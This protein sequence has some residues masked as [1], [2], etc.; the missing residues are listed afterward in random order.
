MGVC[1][2]LVAAAWAVVPQ[3]ANVPAADPS[4]RATAPSSLPREADRFGARPVLTAAQW[5]KLDQSVDRALA[6]LAHSQERDGSFR[7]HES[8]QPAVT[9]LCAMAF[10][11][12]GHVPDEGEYRETL[13]RAVDYVLGSQTADGTIMRNIDG[14]GSQFEANYNH[15]IAGLMLGEVYGMTSSPRQE[16]IRS[17]IEQ[18]LTLSRKEQLRPKRF[19]EDRG[20]W[21]Y[22]RQFGVTDADLSVTAWELM[23]LRSARNAEFDVPEAWIA[24]A[25]EYVRRTFDR[26]ERGFRYGLRGEDGYCSRG[27]V[28]AG[29]VA[30]ALGGEHES[31]MAQLAGKWILHHGFDRYNSSQHPEDR[32]HY[33]AFYCSQ[34]MFQ[35]GGSYWFDFFPKLL[36]TLVANQNRDGSWA[37]EANGNDSKYGNLYTTALAVLALSPPYQILPI[38]QR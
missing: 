7:T 28:G 24:E 5:D 4:T 29:V 1:L 9:S 35:L 13:G 25:M 11:A 17:A 19:P 33:S 20:G 21:R 14:R 6:F 27:M 26:R 34:A 10:L 31:E 32:Y 8:G 30:L 18:A 16:R 3:Q 12:R 22:M 2:L 37:P 36:E 15:A 23:F 38:Y